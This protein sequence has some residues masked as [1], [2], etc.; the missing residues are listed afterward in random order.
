MSYNKKLLKEIMD[1]IDKPTKPS[2]PRNQWQHPG[3]V[4]K[5]PSRNITMKGV[6]YPVLGVDANGYT[7]MM[8]PGQDY[9]FT[10]G[11]VT[12]YPMMQRG[13]QSVPSPYESW[14]KY[15]TREGKRGVRSDDPY[16]DYDYRKYY[17]DMKKG[18]VSYVDPM[19][20]DHYPDTYKLPN[21]PSFSV[22][23]MH[24][25]G[26]PR[27]Q[28]NVISWNGDFTPRYN[29]KMQSGGSLPQYQRKGQVSDGTYVAPK[30]HPNMY[31]RPQSTVIGVSGN[32]EPKDRRHWQ[33]DRRAKERGD[34]LWDGTKKITAVGQYSPEPYSR[35]ISMGANSLMGMVDAY[36]SHRQGDVL[37]RNI[38]L[39]GAIPIPGF[40]SLKTLGAGFGKKLT[41]KAFR[42]ALYG[43]GIDLFG[44][45]ADL[46]DNY[47]LEKKQ[48]GEMIRRADGS[49]SRRGLW[50]NIRANEGSGKKPTK[51]MLKQERN[52]KAKEMKNGGT[53]NP[54]F[55]A[56]PEYVQAN[57]LANMGYGGYYN[58]M[59]ADGGEPN[60]E[61]TF[62]EITMLQ[63]R[64]NKLRQFVGGGGMEEMNNGGY[65]G[66]DGR[67]HISNTPTWS[68]NAGYQNG[69]QMLYAQEGLS[70]PKQEEFSDYESYAQAM[71]EYYRNYAA[72]AASMEQEQMGMQQD[73]QQDAA[74][75][76]M[77]SMN[78]NSPKSI[79]YQGPSVMDMMTS[80]GKTSDYNSRKQL[81][82]KLGISNYRGTDDQNIEMM[83]LVRNNPSVLDNYK[84]SKKVTTPKMPKDD[85]VTYIEKNNL[86]EIIV[87]GKR[88]G[89]SIFNNPNINFYS[90]PISKQAELKPSST[91]LT[92]TVSKLDPYSTSLIRR[93]EPLV[94]NELQNEFRNQLLRNA[95]ILP[96]FGLPVGSALG[97]AINSLKPA[98]LAGAIRMSPLVNKATQIAPKAIKAKAISNIPKN[99]ISWVDKLTPRLQR[100]LENVRWQNLS[101]TDKLAAARKGTSGF[102][103]YGGININP[104]N[105]GKFTASAN[106]ADMGVQEFAAHVLANREDYSSTQVKR[107]NFARNASK[108]NKQEGGMIG[109]E[110]DVTPEELEMLR[111]QG[112]QFEMI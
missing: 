103:K 109:Q 73:M 29:Y 60:E 12:E 42:T 78:V 82:N 21:H 45:A 101:M 38:N 76:P 43:A 52:I 67:R 3:E 18:L 50:D 112:Y 9:R 80:L 54:G 30:Y 53:N 111:A 62:D 83:N 96:S 95:K 46:T 68:G 66:Y 84:T 6:S 10:K 69:G 105:R 28:P 70:I 5:I 87:K 85:E 8:S 90:G 71:D 98:I 88:K 102:K 11:P 56:L 58:P 31:Y 93:D 36:N 19:S 34:Q 61:M 2:I 110:M 72:A 94:D 1:R 25:M 20:G 37:N 89:E 63:N 26:D 74:G 39:I 23:S 75:T 4:T 57:I 22:E 51:E 64:M 106:R 91:E 27:R 107:A 81:A 32:A 7:Q 24:Y 13:G 16:L 35:Y 44:T 99:T 17:D 41:D 86:P 104:A 100:S 79:N 33:N 40:N 48:G 14:F 49:Y 77:R 108:W 15:N 97:F 92:G 55:Y 65:I 59:F 47:G